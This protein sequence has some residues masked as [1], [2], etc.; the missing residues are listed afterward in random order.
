MRLLEQRL[1]VEKALRAYRAQLKAGAHFFIGKVEDGEI[2]GIQ[3]VVIRQEMMDYSGDGDGVVFG[4][5][6]R[7][8]G[9]GPDAAEY[10]LV[11]HVQATSPEFMKKLQEYLAERI[12]PECP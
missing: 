10:P 9:S 7:G 8:T 5:L 2:R 4:F 11:H 3:E 1:S 6:E 12:P